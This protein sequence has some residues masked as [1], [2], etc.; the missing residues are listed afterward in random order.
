MKIIIVTAISVSLNLTVLI[1]GLLPVCEI[2][3]FL[4]AIRI[5]QITVKKIIKKKIIIQAVSRFLRAGHGIKNILYK[6]TIYD[7]NR[8]IVI[9]FIIMHGLFHPE[10]YME[11]SET[12]ASFFPAEIIS[13]IETKND[14]AERLTKESINVASINI[15]T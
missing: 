1:D 13:A 14:S 2:S 15:W 5:N 6:A 12:K 4:L 11:F 8:I 7:Q 3:S 9:I 10:K